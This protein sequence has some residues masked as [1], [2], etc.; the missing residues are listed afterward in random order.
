MAADSLKMLQERIDQLEAEIT[1]Q[2]AFSGRLLLR[3]AAAQEQRDDTLA[4]LEIERETSRIAREKSQH[5]YAEVK[6]LHRVMSEWEHSFLK[7][8]G[9]IQKE[10][11]EGAVFDN[12]MLALSSRMAL[13]GVFY[14][15]GEANVSES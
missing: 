11:R 6:R 4:L 15:G 7:H 10:M 13:D 9:A 12:V 1:E 5:Q 2:Q 8:A 14:H 3:M